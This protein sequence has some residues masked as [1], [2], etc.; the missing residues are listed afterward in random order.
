VG[1]VHIFVVLQLVVVLL[2]DVLIGA[3]VKCRHVTGRV[4]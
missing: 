4:T 3:K 1:R 2:D